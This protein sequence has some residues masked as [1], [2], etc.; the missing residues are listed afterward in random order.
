MDQIIKEIEDIPS[1]FELEQ[2]SP[3][4]LIMERIKQLREREPYD[5]VSITVNLDP[6]P[7]LVSANSVWLRRV[8][9]ILIDNAVDALG[10][11]VQRQIG[12]STSVD[13][14]GVSIDVSDTGTGIDINLLSTLFQRPSVLS[15]SGK[16]RGL[17]IA[18]LI[19]DLYGGKI[20]VKDTGPKGTT[21]ATW[22]PLKKQTEGGGTA[23]DV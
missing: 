14:Q 1:P 11:S 13:E 22:L 23:R 6:S 19:V 2:V 18:R 16:G 7:A 15:P 12:V 20:T 4:A 3:N 9:D 21:V 17:Y 8:L 10:A 5:T